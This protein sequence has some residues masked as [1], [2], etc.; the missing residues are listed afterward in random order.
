ML[1]TAAIITLAVIVISVVLFAIEVIAIDL[2][3]LL[4]MVT[5]ILTGVITP[6]QG[7][8]GFSNK[9]T[10]TVAFMFILS[11]ALLKTGALQFLAHKLAKSFKSH[12]KL[13]FVLM[14]VLIA[15]I[16]GFVNNT[17]VVA[18]FIP[19]MIQIAHANGQ[20]PKQLLIPLSFASI[21]GG[22][23]TLVGTSTNLMVS[24]I[25]SDYGVAE[26]KMFDLTKLGII[27]LVIGVLY[28][29]VV[30]IRLLPKGTDALKKSKNDYL[31]TLRLKTGALST[32]KN[33]S[34]FE[35]IGMQ[36]KGVIAKKS[37]LPVDNLLEAEEAVVDENPTVVVATNLKQLKALKERERVQPASDFLINGHSL[38]KKETSLVEL[39]ITPQSHLVGKPISKN[40]F[41][42]NFRAVPIAI[43]DREGMVQLEDTPLKAGDILLLEIRTRYNNDLKVEA[44]TEN[45]PF[46]L[47][48]EEHL[49]D[50]D[51]RKFYTVLSLIFGVVVASAIGVDIMVSCITAVSVMLVLGIIKMPEAY[52]SINWKVIMIIACALSLGKA[53]NNSGLDELIAHQLITHLGDFGP[54]VLLSGLYLLTSILTELMS[55]HAAAALI[56]P[57][58]LTTASSL[59]VQPLPFIVA[60]TFAASASFMTPMGYHANT[61]VYAAGQYRFMDFIRVGTVLNLVFWLL[62]TFLIPIIYGF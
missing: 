40:Y 1:S 3:A 27:F 34:V 33:L 9:A 5:L 53:M 61:M 28:M 54:I 42:R 46:I 21:F 38:R 10:I 50:F 36:I 37:Y 12:F 44:E 41:I 19:V 6:E 48:S 2:V 35:E 52:Q 60:I 57:I 59:G 4:M 14:L 49:I 17:P 23:L 62:A 39:V 31:S 7:I 32:S 18:V 55:N 25:A 24:G 15:L 47:L 45:P 11:A 16:S 56:L 58:A 22:T 29:L 20:S 51:K 8:E 13:S 26:L 30:G 43:K